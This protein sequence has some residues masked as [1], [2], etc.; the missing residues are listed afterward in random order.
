[1]IFILFIMEKKESGERER[2]REREQEFQNRE[3][4]IFVY[5]AFNLLMRK[6]TVWNVF[7]KSCLRQKAC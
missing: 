2:E 3:S 1:M 7:D 6:E 4:E 5:V